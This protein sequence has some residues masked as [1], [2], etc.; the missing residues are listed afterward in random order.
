M[1]KVAKIFASFFTAKGSPII[2][3][4]KVTKA[5]FDDFRCSDDCYRATKFHAFPTTAT[6]TTTSKQD[7]LSDFKGGSS[8]M[9]PCLLS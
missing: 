4:T 2:D 1:L 8:E 9:Q 6:T 5:D 3:W 7:P